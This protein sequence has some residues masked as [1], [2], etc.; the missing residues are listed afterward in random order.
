MGIRMTGQGSDV[1]AARLAAVEGNSGPLATGDGVPDRRMR[2]DVTPGNGAVRA[3][4]LG[5]GRGAVELLR[6]FGHGAGNF[7]LVALLA[8]LI[9][10][11]WVATPRFLTLQNWQNLA[12]T[13]SVTAMMTLG[14]LL[15]LITGEFDLS[16]GYLI[17]F[18]AM[19]GAFAGSHGIGAGGVIVIMLGAGL[20]VGLVNGILTVYF[21]ISS[22][23]VTLGVGII[24][25]GLTEGVSGGAVI[26]N[27]IPHFVQSIGLDTAGGLAISVWLALAFGLLLFYV[28]EHT[29]LGRRW[30]AI[31]GSERVA[32]MAGI[33][34]G[35]LKIAAFA[36]GGLLVSVGAIFALGQQ[37]S[38]NPGFGPDLL[39]PAYAAAFLGV[40]TWRAGFYNVI[41][42]LVAIIVVAA[43]FNGLSIL[44]VPFWVEPIFD[45]GVLIVAV[46]IAR[47]EARHVR[48]GT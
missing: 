41:G 23:I 9:I 3:S 22:F 19:L 5:E 26:F 36:A 2:S 14:V 25:S 29:P 16:V 15:P 28:L 44:G 31:G 43:G 35:G 40:T 39:L 38:A 20:V 45:G 48:V 12:L 46:M 34:T 47:R 21:H 6:M 17:G 30:Y 37:G 4:R 8:L 33:D 1:E 18:V 32:F 7:S 10:S 11:F 24:L 27:G 13:Q 42:S